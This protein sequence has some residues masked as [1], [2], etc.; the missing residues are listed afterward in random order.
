MIR[1]PNHDFVQVTFWRSVGEDTS[2][3]THPDLFLN[4][5]GCSKDFNIKMKGKPR[6]TIQHQRVHSSEKPKKGKNGNFEADEPSLQ[7]CDSDHHQNM[8][9]EGELSVLEYCHVKE[10]EFFTSSPTA[11]SPIRAS[12]AESVNFSCWDDDCT[13]CSKFWI[14]KRSEEQ[15]SD[16]EAWAWIELSSLLKIFCVRRNWWLRFSR[17]TLKLILFSFSVFREGDV[18]LTDREKDVCQNM[19]QMRRVIS[20]PKLEVPVIET[21]GF[22]PYESRSDILSLIGLDKK[23]LLLTSEMVMDSILHP[24]TML[25]TGRWLLKFDNYQDYSR[26]TSHINGKSKEISRINYRWPPSSPLVLN[27]ARNITEES[28]LFEFQTTSKFGIDPQ[29]VLAYDIAPTVDSEELNY[30]LEEF[31]LESRG[32]RK[33]V[34]DKSS[35]SFLIYFASRSEA[36][37]AVFQLN[38]SS[39]AGTNMHLHL[40]T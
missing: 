10:E 37:R 20:K 9:L 14:R 3:N 27:I 15:F 32:I 34:G 39:F 22:Y 18:C 35:V 19:K 1:Y 21:R 6:T 29:T 31:N 33:I 25:P 38:G 11:E 8:G 28:K 13:N 12:K 23:D 40:Y 4:H 36:E 26:V 24:N 2:S 16:W 5:S 17:E 30:S 7:E